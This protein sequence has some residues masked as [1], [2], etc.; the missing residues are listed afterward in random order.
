MK[1]QPVWVSSGALGH[2]LSPNGSLL[3]WTF[4]LMQRGGR[5]LQQNASLKLT[6]WLMG[7][8]ISIYWGYHWNCIRPHK[9]NPY[10]GPSKHQACITVDSKRLTW[11]Y[12]GDGLG[13][14]V[15]RHQSAPWERPFAFSALKASQQVVRIYTAYNWIIIITQILYEMENSSLE[16]KAKFP[17]QF[18][19]RLNLMTLCTSGERWNERPRG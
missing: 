4:M 17:T 13:L 3:L 10:T 6:H 18:H 8:F 12:W 19:P 11:Q 7:R 2:M 5:K 15:N 16:H 1:E 14:V 9:Q